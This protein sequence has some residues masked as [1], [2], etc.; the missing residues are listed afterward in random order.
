MHPHQTEP[1]LL[2]RLPHGCSDPTA[3]GRLREAEQHRSAASVNLLV[4]HLSKALH[5]SQLTAPAQLLLGIAGE[6]GRVQGW[7]MVWRGWG[8]V[9]LGGGA[10]RERRGQSTLSCKVHSPTPSPQ[11]QQTLPCL[12]V[13]L[14]SFTLPCK[15]NGIA[16]ARS[17]PPA[18]ACNQTP[19]QRQARSHIPCMQFILQ[20]AA[21]FPLN[22][23]YQGYLYRHASILPNLMLLSRPPSAESGGHV[24]QMFVYRDP[25]NEAGYDDNISLSFKLPVREE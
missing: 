17:Q 2:L 6:G 19:C 16:S 7:E 1:H 11:V 25:L 20:V 5:S 23:S 24:H 22:H 8:R 13:P 14:T 21:R 9:E 12:A 15:V 3:E 4:K 18:C 10:R